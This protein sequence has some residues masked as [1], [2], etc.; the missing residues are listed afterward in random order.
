MAIGRPLIV[1]LVKRLTAQCYY[2]P[3]LGAAQPKL[4][5]HRIIRVAIRVKTAALLYI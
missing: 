4:V 2:T 5:P 1:P 3:L